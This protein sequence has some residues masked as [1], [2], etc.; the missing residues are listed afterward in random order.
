VSAG[1]ATPLSRDVQAKLLETMQGSALSCQ[2]ERHLVRQYNFSILRECR[3]RAGEYDPRCWRMTDLDA[4]T[5][6]CISI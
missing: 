6:I 5:I 4:V 3:S 1:S 2:S